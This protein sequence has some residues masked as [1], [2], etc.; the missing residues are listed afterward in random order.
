[1]PFEI[2]KSVPRVT[3]ACRFPPRS[4]GRPAL[5]PGA[6]RCGLQ[7]FLELFLDSVDRPAPPHAEVF[8]LL[9]VDL[10]KSLEHAIATYLRNRDEAFR[11][12]HPAPSSP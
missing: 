7:Q 11:S 6:A 3:F 4:F 10:E 1:M 8:E 2:L 9:G 12:S 5:G